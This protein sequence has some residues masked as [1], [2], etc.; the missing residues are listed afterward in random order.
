MNLHHLFADSG[1]RTVRYA[2]TGAGGGF[3]RTLLAQ[4]RRMPGLVPAV[5]CDR[6]LPAL[7]AVL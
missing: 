1:G 6:D 3:A 2:L 4:T 7:R 5:L